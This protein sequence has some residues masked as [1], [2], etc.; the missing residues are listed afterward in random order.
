MTRQMPRNAR[1][2]SRPPGTRGGK[3]C[4]V[5]SGRG[6]RGQLGTQAGG[7]GGPDYRGERVQ[8]RSCFCLGLCGRNSPAD[9]LTLDLWPPDREAPNFC[10]VGPSACGCNGSPS[11]PMKT[12]SGD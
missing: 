12:E 8:P 3:S 9:T 11:Q 5:S 2:A 7:T 10:R 4:E 6:A 1:A